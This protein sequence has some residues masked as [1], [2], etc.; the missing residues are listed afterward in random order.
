MAGKKTTKKAASKTGL[1]R[2]LSSLMDTR[3]T[4]YDKIQPAA[5]TQE[6]APRSSRVIP[7]EFLVA[8]E[9]QPRIHFDDDKA[10][11]LQESVKSKGILQPILVRKKAQDSYEIIAGERRWRAAQAAGLHEVPAVVKEMTDEEALEV[12]IIENIQRHDLNP[13]EEALGY[14]RLMDE[15]AHTQNALGKAVGKSRSHVANI[16][17]LLAL[18]ESVQAFMRDGKLSMGHAR[19]LITAV[20]PAS[21]AKLVVKDGLSVRQ[22][23]TLAKA[24]KTGGVQPSMGQSK[25]GA[26]KDVDTIAFEKELSASIGL[27][28]EIDGKG[29]ESGVLKI[30]Y[31]TLEQ[32]DDICAKINNDS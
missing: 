16:L 29:G 4:A 10:K 32:L 30:H 18:P 25:P 9:Y 19:A 27:K 28:V 6:T 3:E 24:V 12:A 31:R 2:G 17:R 7:I 13:I 22:T 20:D 8:N 14:K 1:G 23:E 15:F 21:L 26:S 11:E 5:T